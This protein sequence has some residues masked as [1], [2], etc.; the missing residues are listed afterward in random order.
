MFYIGV[1]LYIIGIILFIVS[2]VINI[3]IFVKCS[4]SNNG[5]LFI[6]NTHEIKVLLAAEI[7][8]LIGIVFKTGTFI[9]Q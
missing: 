8:Y 6:L 4:K 7:L 9:T 2:T 1:I 3:I 5:K